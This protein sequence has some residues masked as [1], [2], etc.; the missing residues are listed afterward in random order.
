MVISIVVA[1]VFFVLGLLLGLHRSNVIF[2]KMVDQGQIVFKIAEGGWEGEPD[3]LEDIEE[4]IK[5]G[6]HV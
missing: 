3:A 6:L 4:W 5:H 2:G 1:V